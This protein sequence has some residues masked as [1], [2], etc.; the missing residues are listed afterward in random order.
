MAITKKVLRENTET[1]TGVT[2]GNEFIYNIRP[3]LNI[4]Q[5]AISTVA[6]AAD[7]Y[8]S[9][10]IAE[11]TDFS[12]M[13]K[14]NNSTLTESFNFSTLNAGMKWIGVKVANGTWDVTTA[15]SV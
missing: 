2:A 1:E 12:E 8:V 11:P 6:G 4:S 10:A 13:A 14:V 5:Q 15:L 3:S 9:N 7:I